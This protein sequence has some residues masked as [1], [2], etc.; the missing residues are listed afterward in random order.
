MPSHPSARAD[1]L[2]I[3]GGPS[4]ASAALELARRGHRVVVIERDANPPR[5]AGATLLTPRAVACLDRLDVE[6][7]VTSHRVDR[8]RLT[9]S[10]NTTTVDWPKHPDV[11]RIGLV[12]NA[13]EATLLEAAME[14]GVHLLAGH[15]ATAPI[16]DR[17]FVRGAY[18][19]AP[20]GTRFES[21]AAYTVVADGANSRFGRALG[22]YR[23][24]TWPYGLAHHGSFPSSRH[25]DDTIE[26]VLDLRDRSG[27]PITGHGWMYPAGDGTVTV[28]V[29][30]MSTAPSFQVINPANL[31]K[32]VVD[33][34][35]ERWRME[36]TPTVPTFG[37]RVPMGISIKP[38]AGPTY[39]LIGDAVGAANPLSRTGVE[40]ALQTGI[41]AAEVLDEAI[42]TGDAAHLQRYP[43]LLEERYAA[44]YKV[45]RLANRILGQPTV[46]RRL[47]RTI[48]EHRSV[49]GA[50]V[51]I[52]NDALRG[53]RAGRAETAYRIGR[54][55]SL[56]APDA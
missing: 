20:D 41:F 44:Y 54:A 26:L 30:M 47:E 28:G 21:R 19:H 34:H 1:A 42:R 51:R 49:G 3:G 39:L 38:S 32:R 55:V 6:P 18:V 27:T 50:Y 48:A 23:E 9:A 8:V 31:F 29:V 22:T 5:R 12:T 2:V 13:I 16:I 25:D 37:A 36:T 56:V 40:G 7:P 15:E 33:Q 53:G 17:G 45:G 4:G 14:A 11:P 35:A 24:P 52:T 43:K 46:G 10:G